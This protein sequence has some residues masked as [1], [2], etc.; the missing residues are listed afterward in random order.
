MNGQ[1]M[2]PAAE[3]QFTHPHWCDPA[4]C[5]PHEFGATHHGPITA[6]SAQTDDVWITLNLSRIDDTDD[7]TGQE[8]G[9]VRVRLALKNT[10]LET[11]SG[12]PIHC[13]VDLDRAE[14]DLLITMLQRQRRQLNYPAMEITR[15]MLSDQSESS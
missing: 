7:T 11:M 8:P 2:E 9:P 5:D 13:D 12:A 1:P 3:R 15:P 6:W 4:N 14:L 10:A